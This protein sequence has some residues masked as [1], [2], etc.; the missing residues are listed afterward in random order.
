MNKELHLCNNSR[1]LSFAIADVVGRD[2]SA[3]VLY[4]EDELPLSQTF[5]RRLSQLEPKL[6]IFYTSDAAEIQ[7]FCNLPSF[8]PNILRRN[9]RIGGKFGFQRATRWKLPTLGSAKF[10]IGYLYHPG[11]FTSKPAA[12]HCENVVM[13]ESGFN[14]YVVHPVS[15]WKG[16]LRA[17]SGRDP[18]RLTWGEDRWIKRIEVSKPDLLPDPVRAKAVQLGFADVLAR[19]S[20][21]QIDE[22]G[23]VFAPTPIKIADTG[24]PRALLLTQPIDKVGLAT[25]DAKLSIYDSIAGALRQKKYDVYVKHHPRDDVFAVHGAKALPADFPIELWPAFAL[26]TFDVAVALCSASLTE[27]STDLAQTSIQLIPIAQF[28]RQGLRDWHNSGQSGLAA[29]NN[30]AQDLFP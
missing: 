8:M 24:R 5:K 27:A 9:L 15:I 1:H 21:S 12:T 10:D 6:E 25:N 17:L 23:R 14:N 13:R 28:D 29:I 18:F 22:L 16:A 3:I 7:R 20:A 30:L 11:F 4:L 26:P 19:L 2:A